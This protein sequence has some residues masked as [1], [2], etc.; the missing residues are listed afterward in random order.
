[1]TNRTSRAICNS[2]NMARR[3]EFKTICRPVKTKRKGS[4]EKRSRLVSPNHPHG[5]QKRNM[6]PKRSSEKKICRRKNPTPHAGRWKRGCKAASLLGT[7]LTSFNGRITRKARKDFTSK[8][9]TLYCTNITL[10]KLDNEN[11]R[12]SSP[13]CLTAHQDDLPDDHDNE[14][15]KIPSATQI[16]VRMKAQ[17]VGNDL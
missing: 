17:T 3:I 1:M 4:S 15:E 12:I 11:R 5:K 6:Q 10:R 8:P 9:C 14:I 16:R 13:I 2:G 7:P